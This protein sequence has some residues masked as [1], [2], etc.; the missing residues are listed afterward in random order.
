MEQ[1]ADLTYSEARA[2]LTEKAIRFAQLV[3]TAL[4]DVPLTDAGGLKVDL[5]ADET[6]QIFHALKA[7]QEAGNVALQAIGRNRQ[8]PWVC[9]E[10]GCDR[11]QHSA[12]V[13]TNSEQ[14][15][16]GDGPTQGHYCPEC[17]VTDTGA[18]RRS[19]FK[20]DR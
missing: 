13:D 15:L 19:E 16:K 2:D 20:A 5:E 7:W 17:N 9:E 6:T 8:D 14:T 4:S 10:C 11:I 18:V 1:T 12:W 3:S